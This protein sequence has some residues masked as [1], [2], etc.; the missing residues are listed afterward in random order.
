ME[1]QKV[2]EHS[3]GKTERNTTENG[4]WINSMDSENTYG[5]KKT[6]TQETGKK[7]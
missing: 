2:K 7:E 1:K 4:K 6:N 3:I 5:T